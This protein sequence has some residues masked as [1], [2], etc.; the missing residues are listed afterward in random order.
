MYLPDA[1][2]IYLG[3]TP[4]KKIFL[5]DDLVWPYVN[6]FEIPDYVSGNTVAFKYLGAYRP[7]I[8]PN[9][10]SLYNCYNE[11]G[12]NHLSLNIHLFSDYN[13]NDLVPTNATVNTSGYLKSYTVDIDANGWA[14]FK[15]DRPVHTIACAYD[16]PS[17]MSL[18]AVIPN[19]VRVLAGFYGLVNNI[20]LGILNRFYIP[21]G[22]EVLSGNCVYKNS[23]FTVGSVHIPSTVQTIGLAEGTDASGATQ[24]CLYRL[25]T[26]TKLFYYNGTYDEYNNITW[27][28][29]RKYTS[30]GNTFYAG[31]PVRC[32][33][34]LYTLPKVLEN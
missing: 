24:N 17:D 28:G 34:G 11:P 29:K 9:T 15:F 18:F 26:G 23:L 16:S 10:V 19:T 1:T 22:V 33:D 4:V 21:E 12:E 31:Y 5:K 3:E 2:A 8:N 7:S 32:T 27:L 30:N 20:N 14:L 25:N 6:P 13:G